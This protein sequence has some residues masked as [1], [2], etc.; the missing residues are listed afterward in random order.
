ME[1]IKDGGLDLEK[2]GRKI[3]KKFKTAAEA[4]QYFYEVFI[5]SA[6]KPESRLNQLEIIARDP[7]L[8]ANLL[9]EEF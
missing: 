5:S 8:V 4:E 2:M 9:A 6:A 3:K 7:I 1:M